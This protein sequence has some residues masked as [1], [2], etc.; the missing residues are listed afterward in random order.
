MMA[1]IVDASIVQ[2]F[3]GGT[4]ISQLYVLTAAHCLVNRQPSNLGVLIG[5]HSLSVGKCNQK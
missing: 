5:D 4:I 2:V 3:C 1:G